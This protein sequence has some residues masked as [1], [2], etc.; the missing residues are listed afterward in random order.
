MF[1]HSLLTNRRSAHRL[2]L[3]AL[4]A[5]VH[6]F[7]LGGVVIANAWAVS[8]VEPPQGEEIFYVT[9]GAPAG[10]P[11]P[12]PPPP[13]AAAQT[14]STPD[15]LEPT[16]V[17]SEAVQP[18][19]VPDTASTPSVAE[20]GGGVPGGEEGGEIGG[21][22]GGEIGG[23]LGGE[24]GGCLGCPPGGLGDG[25]GG[26]GTLALDAP[27]PVGGEVAPPV[28]LVRVEP[29]YTEPARRARIEGTVIVQATVD[30]EGRVVDVQVVK[31]L[32]MGLD[33]AAVDAVRK[34]RF[35]P[36]TLRGRPV[37]VFFRLTVAFRLQT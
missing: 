24:L 9:L 25:P 35:R 10:P 34:W 16:P 14:P 18:A 28:A 7:V 21:V 26:A 30:R 33:A 20:N 4:A 29:S 36:A 3:L 19:V 23:Q 6:V 11:P 2:P 15:R 5:A 32:A 1:E 8:A 12:P 22:V 17:R 31:P 27:I 13:P 37:A